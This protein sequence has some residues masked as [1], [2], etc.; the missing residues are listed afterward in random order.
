MVGAQSPHPASHTHIDS[1]R[2]PAPR[3]GPSTLLSPSFFRYHFPS[4]ILHPSFSRSFIF[5]F[6]LPGS[7]FLSSPRHPAAAPL[8][9]VALADIG[10]RLLP[11]PR[12]FLHSSV[13][14]FGSSRCRFFRNSFKRSIFSSPHPGPRPPTRERHLLPLQVSAGNAG[15]PRAGTP[16]AALEFSYRRPRSATWPSR[17]RFSP[18]T[19][20]L[21]CSLCP[22]IYF[23]S[24]L[25]F[26][27]PSMASVVHSLSP[28]SFEP[29][30]RPLPHTRPQPREFLKLSRSLFPASCMWAC[31][32]LPVLSSAGLSIRTTV[33]DRFRNP[34]PVCAS[35]FRDFSVRL[36]EYPGFR[37]R[38]N[39]Y[40]IF[41]FLG[42][43]S[44]GGHT[45]REFPKV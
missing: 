5:F 14:F 37:G 17:F 38:N 18:P 45:R 20:P 19:R 34:S 29:I 32:R 11:D 21:N 22:V 16:C 43:P 1:S 3:R 31:V 7:S 27:R 8:L 2:P 36:E 39:R 35:C 41:V 24:F 9:T 28:G 4:A 26:F 25:L 40:F 42:S 44:I 23:H 15:I 13:R 30:S 33:P 10:I 12:R 6:R